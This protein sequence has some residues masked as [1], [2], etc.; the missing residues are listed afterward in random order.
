[1][2]DIATEPIYNRMM[3]KSEYLR[4]FGK[5]FDW[6]FI[7]LRCTSLLL[8]ELNFLSQSQLIIKNDKLFSLYLFYLICNI[9]K[10]PNS[11]QTFIFHNE[12]TAMTRSNG[13]NMLQN[14]VLS[15]CC[16]LYTLPGVAY[17]KALK[18]NS[19]CCTISYQHIFFPMSSPNSTLILLWYISNWSV[20]N[21]L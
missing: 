3:E 11:S 20:R 10:T 7:A 13:Y 12:C 5:L 2:R 1:M 4:C 14:F 6:T 18:F 8:V 21:S 9:K 15:S 17:R 16:F 19:L